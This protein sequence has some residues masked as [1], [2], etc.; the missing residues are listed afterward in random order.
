MYLNKITNPLFPAVM[1]LA[2]SIALVTAGCA[3][4]PGPVRDP[5]ENAPGVGVSE[6]A[7][8]LATTT[9]TYDSVLLDFL[10]PFFTETTGITVEVISQGTGAVLE[11]GKRGDVDV[12]LV[13]DRET[14]LELVEKGYFV[15]RHDV[16]YNDFIFVGDKDDPAGI[17]AADKAVDGLTLIAESKS[18]FV[19]RGDYS[20]THRME[21]R[22]WEDTGIDPTGENWY[23]SIGQ[24][25]GNTL[26]LANEILGYTMTDRGTYVSIQDYLD[27]VI[28]L[29]GDP[30]LFNQ[31]GIMAVNP[32]IH[33]HVEYDFATM[34]IDFIM[35]DQGQEL[36]NSYQVNHDTLFYPGYGLE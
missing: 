18:T 19:S 26:N 34:Y 16:M 15:D 12:L 14:E 23:L 29:E 21:E 7:I 35:S 11:A 5:E 20:G 8:R 31:Y 13:H 17:Q 24:G 30:A 28:V 27:P 25:M 4:G 33:G 36:I 3:D 6:S 2:L 1:F 10:N 9:S 32:N 22:L